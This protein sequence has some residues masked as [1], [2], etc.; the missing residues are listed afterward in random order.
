[1][2]LIT[3]LVLGRLKVPSLLLL[4]AGVATACAFAEDLRDES[5]WQKLVN[6]V[7]RSYRASALD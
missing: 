2:D 6:A 4:A 3:A 5:P 1:M 7:A